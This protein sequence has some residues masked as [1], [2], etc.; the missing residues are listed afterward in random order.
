MDQIGNKLNNRYLLQKQ[1]G[2]GGFAHVFL[3]TDLELGRQVAVKVLEQNW[4]KD[5]DL[6]ARFRNEARAVAALDH[7]NILL[8]YDFGVAKGAPY[9][10][11]PYINGG[12]FAARMKQGPFTLDEIGF[13]LHQIGS[14]LDY[15]HQHGIVHRDIKPTNLLMRPDGQLV[16]MDFGLAKLLANVSLEE[17]TGVVGTV[18]YMAPEQFQGLVS[19]ASDIYVLGVLLYQ[20]LAGKLPFEG[21]TSEILVGHVHLVPKSL[22]EY[23]TMGSVPPVVVQALDQVLVKALAKHP[24]ERYPTCQALCHAYYQALKTDPGRAARDYHGNKK[25]HQPDFSETLLT[26][27]PLIVPPAPPKPHKAVEV[28]PAMKLPTA[29]E[30]QLAAKQLATP[31][32]PIVVPA[33]P[34]ATI[35]A[36]SPPKHKKMLLKPARLIVTTEPDQVFCATFDLTGETLTL[37]RAP[38]N[39][40]CLPLSIISRHH[41]VLNQ[42]HNE[43][44]ESSYKIVQRKTINALLFQGKEVHEK[45]LEHGDIIEIGKR[46]YAEY[47]VKLTYQGPEYGFA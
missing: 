18:A 6:L 14:A 45:V 23:A 10:D 20:M 1:I 41:A 9:L 33:E 25:S 30:P 32:P 12:T 28:A 38:D 13:Y 37:G 42:L 35:I 11:M 19:A 34:D 39:S 24:V 2:E 8:I 46:G 4:A 22:M 40:L 21:N 7:P 17:Q 31:L 43:F 47:I 15:A 3:A 44:Q 26:D 36:P 16:L 27:Q 29:P 5:K